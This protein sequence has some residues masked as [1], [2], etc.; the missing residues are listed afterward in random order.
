MLFLVPGSHA[1]PGTARRGQGLCRVVVLR[2]L[3]K[4][5]ELMGLGVGG[6]VGTKGFGS[7]GSE[8]FIPWLALDSLSMVGPRKGWGMG[9][10]LKAAGLRGVR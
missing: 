3:R 2:G 10:G 5:Q 8:N 4:L 9:G 6:A 7:V 1:V